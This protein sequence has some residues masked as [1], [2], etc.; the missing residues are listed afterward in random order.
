[1]AKEPLDESPDFPT[2]LF[3][4]FKY[5]A[6]IINVLLVFHLH[7]KILKKIDFNSTLVETSSGFGS[8]AT[9]LSTA[10]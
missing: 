8:C 1:V 6:V 2:F 7:W 4:R 5:I 10:S 9:T 3:S